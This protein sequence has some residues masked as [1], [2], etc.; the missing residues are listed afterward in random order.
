MAEETELSECRPL[1]SLV[2]NTANMMIG[3]NVESRT[4][5]VGKPTDTKIHMPLA[6]ILL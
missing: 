1:G 2:E 4:V 6:C 3:E 5:L